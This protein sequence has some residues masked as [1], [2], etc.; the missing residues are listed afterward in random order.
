MTTDRARRRMTNSFWRLPGAPLQSSVIRA[1]VTCL[2]VTL[3]FAPFVASFTMSGA[4]Y[5]RRA[6]AFYA[7][8]AFLVIGKVAAHHPLPRFGAAN[9]V[10]L[11]RAAL[12]AGIA[13]LIG[14]SAS[15]VIAILIVVTVVVVLLLDGVDGWLARRSGEVSPFG[16]RF[17]METDAALI[18]ILSVIVWQ[19][20]KA[21]IWVIA[22]GLMRYGFV[23]AGWVLPWMTAPLRSTLRG[24][25]VAVAQI[26]G[27]ALALVPFVQ[28]PLS[29][30]I[31][32]VTLA[33]LVWSFAVDIAWLKRQARATVR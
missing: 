10:T 24:K 15:D 4:D 27:L 29:D 30:A 5:I 23:V 9:F 22:C 14:E 7:L 8:A 2:L 28:P 1:V 32:A 31:A 21:G 16:A 13:G 33:T 3:G 17:D 12:T 6:L 20:G 18:L 11:L 19:H 25:A 26:V